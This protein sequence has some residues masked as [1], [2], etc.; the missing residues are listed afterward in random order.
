[1][2]ILSPAYFPDKLN[3]RADYTHKKS[4]NFRPNIAISDPVNPTN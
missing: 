3:G 1:M 4:G 2:T